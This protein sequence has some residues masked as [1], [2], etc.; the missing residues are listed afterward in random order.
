[1]Y[2]M[3]G[4][5]EIHPFINN[6]PDEDAL[7]GEISTH[8]KTF[9]KEIGYYKNDTSPDVRLLSFASHHVEL[10]AGVETIDKAE[11]TDTIASL[12]LYMSQWMVD[13]SIEGLIATQDDLL[14]NLLHN[15]STSVN[16]IIIGPMRSTEY[17]GV[18]VS[19]PEYIR[20]KLND[21]A[22]GSDIQI[23]YSDVA[24]RGQYPLS[25]TIVLLP[26]LPIDTFFQP[27]VIVK[28]HLDAMTPAVRQEKLTVMV[29]KDPATSV[30]TISFK[31]TNPHDGTSL[32]VYWSVVIYGEAGDNPDAIK[33]AIKEK[34]LSQSSK[35]ID[36]WIAIF[37]DL[38]MSTEF[39]IVPLWN[40][41]SIPNESLV[42]GLFS[43]TLKLND[44]SAIIKEGTYRYPDSHLDTHVE[45]SLIYYRSLPILSC[46]NVDNKVGMRFIKDMYKDYF[47]MPSS[48][49]EYSRMSERTRGWVAHLTNMIRVAE[50]V[51]EYSEVPREMAK[52]KRGDYLY[53]ASEYDGMLYILMSQYSYLNILLPKL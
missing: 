41:Y 52:V 9:T 45:S 34:I 32:Q 29:G 36:E 12:I 1:M 19:M 16:S 50:E 26:I 22:R 33:Q 4:F 27:M 6:T 15:F 43:P 44:L 37:P 28:A 24:F 49:T 35:T 18:M 21:Y 47:V 7:V 31:Y 23:W 39:T 38:F 10:E 46:C 42:R 40:N 48:D 3:K 5:I 14:V 8:S 51:T 13:R 30:K 17:R 20:F 11:V 53:L 2:V 25:E